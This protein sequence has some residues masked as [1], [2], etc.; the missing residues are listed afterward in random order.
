ME[1]QELMK[2]EQDVW[3]FILKFLCDY[4]VTPLRTE[5]A[6]GLKIS[7]QL[8]QYRINKLAE[9]GWVQIV[10]LKKRNISIK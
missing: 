4:K 6:E 9:K 8:V 7:P 1:K 5:I 2:Q 10:P 3:E